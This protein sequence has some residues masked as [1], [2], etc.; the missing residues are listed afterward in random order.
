MFEVKGQGHC[1]LKSCEVNISRHH[2]GIFVR[3]TTNLHLDS[4]VNWL[5]FGG[6]GPCKLTYFEKKCSVTRIEGYS[7]TNYLQSFSVKFQ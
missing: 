7:W 2:L 3:F 5:D 1:D 4:R 6:K